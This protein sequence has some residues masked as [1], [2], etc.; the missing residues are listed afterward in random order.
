[1]NEKRYFKRVNFPADVQIIRD[2]NILRGDLLDISLKGALIRIHEPVILQVGRQTTVRIHLFS[3]AISI[4]AEADV[5]H[6]RGE[7]FGFKFFRIDAESIGHL[8]RLL[9]FNLGNSEEVSNEL[10]FILKKQENNNE[11]S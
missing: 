11:K 4:T 10:E 2:K 8:R 9:E 6:Q 1:M 5:V 7:D 3:S